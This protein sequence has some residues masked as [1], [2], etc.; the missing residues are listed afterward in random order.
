MLISSDIMSLVFYLLYL[1]SQ[2]HSAIPSAGAGVITS[3]L[4]I[5][6]FKIKGRKVPIL[7]LVAATLALLTVFGFLVHCPT[8]DMAGVVVPYADGYVRNSPLHIPLS[9]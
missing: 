3:G 6:F 4:I 2:T 8:P 7:G 9:V 1:L 5:Y